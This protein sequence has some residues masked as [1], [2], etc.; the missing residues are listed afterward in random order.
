MNED[1]IPT[2]PVRELNK[3]RR[4]DQISSNTLLVFIGL[5][6]ALRLVEIIFGR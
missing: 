5:D 1:Q 3:R 6:V 2:Q 4:E